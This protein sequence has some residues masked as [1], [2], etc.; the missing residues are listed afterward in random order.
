MLFGRYSL[1]TGREY[2]DSG[3]KGGLNAKE[4]RAF[5]KLRGTDEKSAK[6]VYGAIRELK[7]IQPK[8]DEAGNTTT[9]RKELQRQSLFENS[10]L[11]A[12][13]KEQLDRMLLAGE[14]EKPADYSGK[15]AFRITSE[16]EE[17]QQKR[18]FRALDAGISAE[19]YLSVR[20]SFPENAKKADKIQTIFE[21]T[22]LDAEQK[23]ELEEIMLKNEEQENYYPADY[24]NEQTLKLSTHVRPGT[25]THLS[26]KHREKAVAGAQV[27]IPEEMYLYAWDEL[28]NMESSEVNGRSVGDVSY[29]KKVFIDALTQDNAQRQFLY[30]AFGV[31][32]KAQSGARFIL[33]GAGE[34]PVDAYRNALN[35]TYG[36]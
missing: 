31:S 35:I 2:I 33:Y 20:E 16:L 29:K 3:F 21:R 23:A 15:D 34:N 25:D 14:G 26:Q 27:G 13:Q 24:T 8:K 18:A 5:E 10:S 19:T 32:K 7:N 4:S 6:T 36:R 22:D 17:G 1:P 30:G 28:G 12:K 9:S 11:T